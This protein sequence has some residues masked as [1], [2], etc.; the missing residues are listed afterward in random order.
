MKEE[1]E[2]ERLFLQLEFSKLAADP[3]SIQVNV[4]IESLKYTFGTFQNE[5][6]T[7]SAGERQPFG[8]SGS[9]AD[10]PRRLDLGG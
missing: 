2:L 9:A 3:S 6:S 8:S 1:N 4:K 10:M 5:D 7:V